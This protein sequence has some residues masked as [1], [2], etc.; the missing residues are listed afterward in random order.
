GAARVALDFRGEIVTLP[1][2]KGVVRNLT[3]TPGAHE[4][5]PSW[6]PDGKS[7][8]YFSDEGGEYALHV[9]PAD[10]KGEARVY[11]LGGAG[12]YEDALW[13]P[14]SKKIAYRD[15]SWTLFWIDLD[16]GA[17]KKVATEPRYA[18]GPRNTRVAAWSP[19]SNWLAYTL[20]T[21]AS[22]RV[23]YV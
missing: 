17:V 9:R 20:S 5:S 1:V 16:K 2:E 14:D 18:T 13:S 12:Y 8:A 3:N 4:R 22:Y 23:V 6:S 19:D 11:K 15:N 10:G 7:I 21:L